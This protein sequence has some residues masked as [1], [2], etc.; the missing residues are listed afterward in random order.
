RIANKTADGLRLEEL[1]EEAGWD[2]DNIKNVGGWTALRKM[3]S[4]TQFIFEVCLNP[5]AISSLSLVEPEP[6][7]RPMNAQEMS[8]LPRG[9][10]FVEKSSSIVYNPTFRYDMRHGEA[11]NGEY[12]SCW[13]GYILPNESVLRDFEV[14]DK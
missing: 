9:T 1:L 8:I 11:I 3:E 13:K 14:E 12:M 6:K 10:A 5:E 2:I 4:T 7:M